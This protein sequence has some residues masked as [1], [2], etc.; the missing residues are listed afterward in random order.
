MFGLSLRQNSHKNTTN[1]EEVR[2]SALTPRILFGLLERAEN[3]REMS[4]Y[5]ALF[6]WQGGPEEDV[7]EEAFLDAFRSVEPIIRLLAA[8]HPEIPDEGLMMN[9]AL[10]P[11]IWADNTIVEQSLRFTIERIFAIG[12]LFGTSLS[13]AAVKSAA[14]LLRVLKED[15][16]TP[17]RLLPRIEEA[18]RLFLV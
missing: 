7:S 5:L 9:V 17:R 1:K 8:E 13:P 10:M 2:K 14:S 15:A 6:L 16:R 11:E 4:E 3:E 12:A 18:K